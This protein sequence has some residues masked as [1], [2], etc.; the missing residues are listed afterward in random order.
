MTPPDMVETVEAGLAA[1]AFDRCMFT[2][3]RAL[4]Q[5]VSRYRQDGTLDSESM[6]ALRVAVAV[7]ADQAARRLSG[8]DPTSS[9]RS[10]ERF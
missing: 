10:R 4:C 2:M 6:P 8:Q 7:L 1:G 5:I 3:V 9:E